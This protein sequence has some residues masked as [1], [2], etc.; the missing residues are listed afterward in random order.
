MKYSWDHVADGILLKR[1]R[2]GAEVFL[3]Y[4]D[5]TASF[6]DSIYSTNDVVTDDD[7]IAEYFV[8]VE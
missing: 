3:R 8:G 5:D 6:I 4:G 2:D 7:V 1:L